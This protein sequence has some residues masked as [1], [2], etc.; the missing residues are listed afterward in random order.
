MTDFNCGVLNLF[1][2]F[3]YEKDLK[4]DSGTVRAERELGYLQTFVAY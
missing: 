1:L 3:F 2:Y 4:L